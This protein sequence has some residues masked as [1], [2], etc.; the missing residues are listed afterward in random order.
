MEGN[1]LINKVS[2]KKFNIAVFGWL[3]VVMIAALVFPIVSKPEA[4]YDFPFIPAL[5]EQSRILF[6][7]VPT[8]W[9]T[10]VAFF[11]SMVYGIKYLR[12][13]NMED[14]IKSVSSAGVGVLFCILA[15][16]TGSVWAKFSW[17]SFWNWDPRET[18]IAVLLLIY[19]AYFGLRSSLEGDEKRAR[20]SAV[21][22]ILAGITTPFL[23]FVLP[24]LV[25]SLHPEPIVNAGGKVHMN[26]TMLTVFLAS[27]LGFTGLF[28]WMFDL[29]VR[30]AR[31]EKNHHP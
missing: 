30:L 22:A 17:G 23:I 31:L 9:V 10:V 28:A 25:S 26:V 27:L 21:Y 4:W 12:S 18:S 14:D 1:E 6:F 11:L 16:I 3:T 2:M 13:N 5:G 15:T 20:L 24:R 19:G 29:K 7:H 8:A